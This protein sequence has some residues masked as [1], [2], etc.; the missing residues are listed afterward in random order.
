LA[1]TIDRVKLEDVMIG[2]ATLADKVKA[3]TAKMQGNLAV[4]KQLTS[5]MTQFDNWFEI[6]PGTKRDHKELPTKPEFFDDD[7]PAADNTD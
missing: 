5:T 2:A 1:I 4:L 7:G 6:L 3:G